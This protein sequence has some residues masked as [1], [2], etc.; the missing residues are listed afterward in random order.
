MP[1]T[2]TDFVQLK[3]WLEGGKKANII[4]ALETLQAYL[5]QQGDARAARERVQTLTTNIPIQSFLPCFD[6]KSLEQLQLIVFVFGKIMEET[7][8]NQALLVDPIVGQFLAQGYKHP[9]EIVRRLT[10][11]QVARCTLQTL[12]ANPELFLDILYS[13]MLDPEISVE[14]V[15]VKIITNI[16]STLDGIDAIFYK[17]KALLVDKL[18]GELPK[19][20]N[21]INRFRVYELMTTLCGL[22]QEA[23]DAVSNIGLF[24]LFNN[25]FKN[26]KDDILSILNFLE[27]F[28]ALCLQ[29]FKKQG[30]NSLKEEGSFD[31]L[32]AI[33]N[34]NQEDQ[35]TYTFILNL[36]ADISDAAEN[37]FFGEESKLSVPPSIILKL[38]NEDLS[39]TFNKESQIVAISVIGALCKSSVKNLDFIL[40]GDEEKLSKYLVFYAD[41]INDQIAQAFYHSLGSILES[42]RIDDERAEKIVNVLESML[43]KRIEPSITKPSNSYIMNYAMYNLRA[44]F[45]DVRCAI[46]H[47]LKGL[48]SR[49]N[50]VKNHVNAHSEFFDYIIDRNTEPNKETKEWKFNTIEVLHKTIQTHPHAS[51]VDAKHI[52]NLKTYLLRGAYIGDKK[53]VQAIV[54]TESFE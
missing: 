16:A 15:A 25:D 50:L 40:L 34:D 9:F 7:D 26:S 45:S 28:K 21:E 13:G 19:S 17:H 51:G 30:A 24:K 11:N 6:T 18:L 35:L 32:M 42:P 2:T 54:A 38:F 33:L 8:V 23:F 53:E 49:I 20:G 22:S 10:I 37:L 3:T 36:I 14:K 31:L 44:P 41:S 27:I 46:Y 12:M 1:A 47:F 48:C 43:K 39:N 5:I 29:S 4:K 52:I